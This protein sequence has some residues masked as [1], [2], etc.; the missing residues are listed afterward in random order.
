MRLEAIEKVLRLFGWR[1]AHLSRDTNVELAE[2]GI[3]TG[4]LV[5]TQCDR[6]RRLRPTGNRYVWC[7][8]C[9]E[10]EAQN[11]ALADKA[12][13]RLLKGIEKAV[14]EYVDT[15]TT[16]PRGQRPNDE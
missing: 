6:I 12:D 10:E 9:K 1:V 11:N 4:D 3:V 8:D 5:Y 13:I 2:K 15:I 16:I 7:P 14:T